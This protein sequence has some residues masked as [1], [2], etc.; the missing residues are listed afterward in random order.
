[1]DELAG[2]TPR[3]S[4]VL[5]DPGGGGLSPVT[6]SASLVDS[7]HIKLQGG[8]RPDAGVNYKRQLGNS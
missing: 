4:A 5:R 2:E 3:F 6:A 8:R 1:M 7:V